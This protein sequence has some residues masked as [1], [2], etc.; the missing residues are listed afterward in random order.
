[1]LP[2]GRDLGKF[3]R[4][5]LVVVAVAFLLG[6]CTLPPRGDPIALAE[7]EEVNDPLAPTNRFLFGVNLGLDKFILQP[8][9][10]TYRDGVPPF[11]KN[12][13]R[14][15]IFNARLPLSFIHATLQG[16]GELM[17][18]T[19]SR[20]VTNMLFLWTV[21]IEGDEALEFE[22]A[23]QTFA[24]WTNP[25]TS[26]GPYLML[27]VL[28]PSNVRDAIGRG[29]DFFIDPIG[30]AAST[31]IGLTRAGTDAVD[32]RSRNIED[33]RDLERNSLDFYATVRSLYRQRRAQQIRNDQVEPTEPAPTIGVD[34]PS[35][36]EGPELE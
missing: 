12:V 31:E 15:I 30:F 33:V 7:Y 11:L 10:V 2:M 14:N 27:P 8:V 23:G 29:V 22:D 19:A 6:A 4:A 21:D 18:Q 34:F 25:E 13:V 36:S 16:N 9:A 3:I 32:E 5:S 20:F 26:G 17:D 24:A 35:I 28:G 1:M